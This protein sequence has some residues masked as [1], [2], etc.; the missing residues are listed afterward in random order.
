M[1]SLRPCSD[2]SA[3]PSF[4]SQPEGK[5]GQGPPVTLP[6][7]QLPLPTRETLGAASGLCILRT[8][9]GGRGAHSC[10]NQGRRCS[11][12]P[13]ST[14]SLGLNNTVPSPPLC[15]SGPRKHGLHLPQS[16]PPGQP[17]PAA[18][19]PTGPILAGPGSPHLLSRGRV[20]CPSSSCPTKRASLQKAG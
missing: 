5:I 13:Q 15:L 4:P 16:R 18:P 12:A 7:N 2:S 6:S 3:T 20:G 17:G 11:A 10:Q 1:R 19:G 9:P 8:Q 14:P